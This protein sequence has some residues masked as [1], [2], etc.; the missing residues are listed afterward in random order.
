MLELQA[1][2][3]AY[4]PIEALRGVGRRLSRA[5]TKRVDHAK[6]ELQWNASALRN[7]LVRGAERKHSRL[8]QLSGRLHALSPLA[9]LSRGYAVARDAKGHALTSASQFSPHMDFEV[10]L[11]DGVVGARVT[12]V[13][14]QP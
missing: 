9:T 11:R 2:R 8:A 14:E 12:R 3:A 10:A 1:L 4:G 6:S 13:Q 5:L 7:R